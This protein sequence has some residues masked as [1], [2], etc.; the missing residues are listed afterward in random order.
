MSEPFKQLDE[1]GECDYCSRTAYSTNLAGKEDCGSCDLDPATEKNERATWVYRVV[2]AA[3]RAI[4]YLEG[5]EGYG[6]TDPDAVLKGLRA[7][8]GS[9]A[10]P[11]AA[12]QAPAP[13]ANTENAPGE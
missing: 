5:R 13:S 4:A 9:A 12:N 8:L 6:G 11:L 3:N 7:A 2:Y 10:I 1:P